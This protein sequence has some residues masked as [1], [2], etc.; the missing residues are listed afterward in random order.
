MGVKALTIYASFPMRLYQYSLSI[1][2][3]IYK[4]I[5]NRIAYTNDDLQN[6]IYVPLLVSYLT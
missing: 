3:D 2:L 1:G 6:R 4:M 5:W